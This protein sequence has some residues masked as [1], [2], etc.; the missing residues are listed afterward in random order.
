MATQT[1]I[2]GGLTCDYCLSEALARIS[3]T[4]SDP[5]DFQSM[6]EAYAA[7][8]T[9]YATHN[10]SHGGIVRFL[11]GDCRAIDAAARHALLVKRGV[12]AAWTLIT[13]ETVL[14]SAS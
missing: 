2:A 10:N 3:G 5:C 11:C 9:P 7:G 6:E 14:P 8:W 13:P 4:P 1:G 12:A